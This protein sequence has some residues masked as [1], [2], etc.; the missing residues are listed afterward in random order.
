MHMSYIIIFIVYIPYMYVHSQSCA[1]ICIVIITINLLCV[2]FSCDLI[3][4]WPAPDF[5]TINSAVVSGKDGHLWIGTDDGLYMLNTSVYSNDNR[6]AISLISDIEGSVI[7]LSW[8]SGLLGPKGWGLQSNAFLLTNT[9]YLHPQDVS[10]NTGSDIYIGDRDSNCFGLLAIGTSDKIY[11]YDGDMIWFEWVSIWEYGL[12]GVVDGPPITMTFVPTG[13]LYIG[14]NVSLTRLNINYTFD[15]IGPSEGLPYN[16]I[17][18]LHYSSYTPRY[19]LPMTPPSDLPHSSLGGTLFVGSQKGWSLFDIIKSEFIGYFYGP[20]WHPGEEVLGIA[21]AGFNM[22]VVLTDKGF[23]SIRPEDWTLE[24]K[25]LHYQN[26]LK[27][28]TREPGYLSL[29][30]SLSLSVSLSLSLSLSVSL[31]LSLSFSVYLF[32]CLSC[33]CCV[34]LCLSVSLCPT[35]YILSFSSYIYSSSLPS[36]YI[37]FLCVVYYIT[38]ISLILQV[39]FQIVHC[40]ILYL[41]PVI[42]NQQTMMDYGHHG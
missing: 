36:V 9:S 13:V 6:T 27:R 31:C 30:L 35:S 21:A 15:R 38:F 33:V 23:A 3:S 1:A 32:L 2:L 34:S 10:F 28:H 41:H 16:Q 17:T 29:S 18:S 7:S 39:L 14:N 20:R 42:Q 24:K 11:F 26:M 12:G 25:A 19:P 37:Y 40:R 4:H 8:R 5:S 22:S